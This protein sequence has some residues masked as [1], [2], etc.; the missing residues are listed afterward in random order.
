MRCAAELTALGVTVGEAEA[1]P[2]L[3]LVE[4][5]ETERPMSPGAPARRGVARASAEPAVTLRPPNRRRCTGSAWAG[6]AGPAERD[7]MTE[8]LRP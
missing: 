5:G 7:V 6:E 8:P 3:H 1:P 4:T 2:P